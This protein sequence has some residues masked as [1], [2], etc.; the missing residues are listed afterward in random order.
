KDKP[1]KKTK[2]DKPSFHR[3]KQC[4]LDSYVPNVY[5]RNSL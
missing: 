5:N 1:T 2:E 4:F 3:E